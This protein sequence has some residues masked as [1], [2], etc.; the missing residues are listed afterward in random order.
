MNIGWRSSSNQALCIDSNEERWLCRCLGQLLTGLTLINGPMK[1][2]NSVFS[3]KGN[4]LYRCTSNLNVC[5]IARHKWLVEALV[6]VFTVY[7]D[8]QG[9]S[10]KRSPLGYAWMLFSGHFYRLHRRYHWRHF[11]RKFDECK[12]HLWYNR[13]REFLTKSQSHDNDWYTMR[14]NQYP[15]LSIE[16]FWI[17][18]SQRCRCNFGSNQKSLLVLCHLALR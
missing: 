12:I 8:F 10:D 13:E 9:C 7:I 1:L 11:S 5:M 17:T 2:Y 14:L 15:I 3:M 16:I 4:S 18:K 6:R